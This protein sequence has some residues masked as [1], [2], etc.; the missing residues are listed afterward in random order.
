MS[1]GRFDNPVV[2]AMAGFWDLFRK[3]DNAK[4]LTDSDRFD[5]KNGD[6]H[7][8]QLWIGLRTFS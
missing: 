1:H 8:C 4:R 5:G 2:A 3:Q 6:Y 7:G